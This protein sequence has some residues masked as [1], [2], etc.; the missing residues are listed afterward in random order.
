MGLAEWKQ[1]VDCFAEDDINTLILWT[2]G[3]FRSKKFPITWAIQRRS[4]QHPARLRPRAD[5]L[6]PHEKDSRPARLHALR[7]RRREPVPARTSRTESSEGRWLARRPVRHPEH[8]LESLPGQ[9]RVATLHARVHP[10]KW[11][12]TSIPMPMACSSSRPTTPSAI[13]PTAAN[14]FTTTSSN[15]SGRSPTKCGKQ[16]PDATILV[17]PHYFTGAKVPG[18]STPTAARQ[19]FDP[20]W[21]V[22]FAPHSAHFDLSTHQASED[23]ACSGA[24]PRPSTRR[25]ASPRAARDAHENGVT[26]FIPSLEAFSYVATAPEAGEP[27][28]VGKRHRPVRLRSRSAEG[29]MPYN[30]L[31][32]RVQRFAYQHIQPGARTRIHGIPTSV[33]ANTSSAVMPPPPQPPTSSS[34]NASGPSKATGTGPRRS[35]IRPSSPPTPNDSSGRPANSPNTTAISTPSARSRPAME[36]PPMQPPARWPNSRRSSPIVGMPKV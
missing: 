36:R 7:L 13:A 28:V 25:K 19:P 24:T 6:R 2:A 5:R 22:I 35:S 14:T 29:K 32:V 8:R 16:K 23:D 30:T 18:D 33:S 21:G 27:W 31:P 11:S 20:R 10:T 34:C 26:G 1:A 3:G 15:S 4:R 17:F 9:G 12:S